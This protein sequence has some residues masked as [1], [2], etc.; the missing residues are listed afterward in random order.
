M[1]AG[2]FTRRAAV[3]V[4]PRS[5]LRRMATF[6]RHAAMSAGKRETCCGVVKSYDFPPAPNG[7]TRQATRRLP[8]RR[9]RHTLT[10]L[11][12]VRIHVTS[13]ASNVFEPI[14]CAFPRA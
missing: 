12:L 1:A 6:A 5:R 4:I 10:E 14:D 2:A 7:V 13:A 9:C 3:E 8:V 11:S